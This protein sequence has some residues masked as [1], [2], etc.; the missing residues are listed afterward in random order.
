LFNTNDY[1]L[2]LSLWQL[3]QDLKPDNGLPF[4]GYHY[5]SSDGFYRINGSITTDLN[6]PDDT[7]EIFAY[8]DEARCY[9]LGA[10]GNV[11][12][13]FKVGS[14]FQQVELD[15]PPYNFGTAHKFHSGEFRSDNMQR[16]SFWNQVLL[17]MQLKQ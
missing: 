4:P 5:S 16:A 15:D 11:G 14:T 8:C 13:P 12:G 9:A 10:Q 17:Q 7:Y 3:N 6:F 2:S 1:A